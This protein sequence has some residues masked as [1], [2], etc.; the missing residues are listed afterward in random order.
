MRHGG[1]NT[2]FNGTEVVSSVHRAGLRKMVCSLANCFTCT[3]INPS[4][5]ES[6]LVTISRSLSAFTHLCRRGMGRRLDPGPSFIGIE[7]KE[8]A[9][10]HLGKARAGSTGVHVMRLPEKPWDRS[11]ACFPTRMGAELPG[12]ADHF[13]SVSSISSRGAPV[14]AAPNAL[15][16][17]P[18]DRGKT[19]EHDRNWSMN[20][21][22]IEKPK[23]TL[24]TSSKAMPKAAQ[25]LRRWPT[26]THF[27]NGKVSGNFGSDSPG[28]ASVNIANH[29]PFRPVSF[30]KT[31]VCHP[32]PLKKSVARRK[33]GF[34]LS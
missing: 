9:E 24:K 12:P 32:P 22:A 17:D 5:P 27:R 30:L 3:M 16:G 15:D 4:L 13:A 11:T 28:P 8:V 10:K 26:F 34:R 14:F 20:W 2:R 25:V 31:E 1:L 7:A 21:T 29:D 6:N 23:A 18:P 19:V 33:A